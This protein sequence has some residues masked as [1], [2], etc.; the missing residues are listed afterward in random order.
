M[1]EVSRQI[2][3]FIATELRP[4]LELDSLA[5]TDVLVESGILDSLGMLRIM[6]FLE[7]ELSLDLASDE[8]V[9]ENFSTIESIRQMVIRQQ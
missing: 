1:D 7:E 9:L 2:K 5:D 6:A 4:D 3:S 8:V